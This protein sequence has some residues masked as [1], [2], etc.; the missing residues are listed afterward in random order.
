MIKP[1]SIDWQK[2][3]RELD[4]SKVY[5]DD[6][7]ALTCS[8]GKPAAKVVRQIRFAKSRLLRAATMLGAKL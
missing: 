5:I 7:L 3:M 8:M 2:V 4:T 6:A 1:K